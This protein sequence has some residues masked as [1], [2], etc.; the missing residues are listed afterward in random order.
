V[1]C[2]S[3][4]FRPA[5][6]LHLPALCSL[7]SLFFA[8]PSPGLIINPVHPFPPSLFPSRR[9]IP[10]DFLPPTL[11]Y[12][13]ISI[14]SPSPLVFPPPAFLFLIQARPTFFFPLS[15]PVLAPDREFFFFYDPSP[16]NFFPLTT[17]SVS[18]VPSFPRLSPALKSP[19]DP[20]SPFPPPLLTPPRRVTSVRCPTPLRS[21]KTTLNSRCFESL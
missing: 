10:S 8:P 13:P 4:V 20:P 17:C 7:F 9:R 6:S 18:P 19:Y 5:T 11:A 3:L 21:L 15:S 16:A 2:A 12:R 1:N 14:F